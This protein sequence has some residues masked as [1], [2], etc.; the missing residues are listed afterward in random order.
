MGINNNNRLFCKHATWIF[1][2]HKNN[3]YPYRTI[4]KLKMT[5]DLERTNMAQTGIA[6]SAELEN[7]DCGIPDASK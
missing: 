2:K 3:T 4:H 6:E 1:L 5:P 7:S